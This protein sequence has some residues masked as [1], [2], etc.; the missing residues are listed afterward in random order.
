[1]VGHS[2]DE[3]PDDDRTAVHEVDCW[4]KL[5]SIKLWLGVSHSA[6]AETPKRQFCT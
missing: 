4:R 2:R 3:G 1:M 5:S 6:L